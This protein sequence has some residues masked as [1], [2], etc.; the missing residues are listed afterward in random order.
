[1]PVIKTKRKSKILGSHGGDY[2]SGI[3][4]GAVRYKLTD[5]SDER[6]AFIFRVE[7]RSMK[8]QAPSKLFVCLPSLIV[9]PRNKSITFLLNVDKLPS[10]TRLNNT[11]DR[12]TR[13]EKKKILIYN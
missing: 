11:E 9:Y 2:N 6:T 3:L 1:M 5:V 12:S 13:T 4:S 10:G 8:Q 7:S